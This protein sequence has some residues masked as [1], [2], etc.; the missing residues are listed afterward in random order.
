MLGLVSKD[1]AVRMADD[2]ELDLRATIKVNG[3]YAY[4]QGF[5][6]GGTSITVR[7]TRDGTSDIS[8]RSTYTITNRDQLGKPDTNLCSPSIQNGE[9]SEN[10][11]RGL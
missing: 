10:K 7:P 9:G 4:E 11:L 6:N 3:E 5:S 8:E 2:A 1:E